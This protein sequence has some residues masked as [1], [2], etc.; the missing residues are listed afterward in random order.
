MSREQQAFLCVADITGYTGYLNDSELEH[1]QGTLTDLLELLVDREAKVAVIVAADSTRPNGEC[2]V[3]TFAT[4]DPAEYDPSDD[5]RLFVDIWLDSA[6]HRVPTSTITSHRGAE[7]C[8]WESVTFLTLDDRQYIRD[9][10]GLLANIVWFDGDATLP[11]DAADTGY[12]HQGLHLW[13]SADQ[14]VAFIV[15]GDIVEAWPTPTSSI[16]IAC[17]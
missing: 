10:R 17:D 16:P 15:D 6:G 11:A 9:P 12:Q 2:A 3:E 13:L 14:A 8:G 4:C 7:H 1:A 5:G